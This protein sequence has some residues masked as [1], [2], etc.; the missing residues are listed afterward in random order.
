MLWRAS[1]FLGGHPYVMGLSRRVMQASQ[2]ASRR[3]WALGCRGRGG[4]GG[5]QVGEQAR[6]G[7]CFLGEGVLLSLFTTERDAG[8]TQAGT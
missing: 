1:F 7:L 4:V 5:L 3:K 2:E 6:E 8:G